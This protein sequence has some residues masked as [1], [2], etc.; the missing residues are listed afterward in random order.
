[1][2][3]IVSALED[4]AAISAS[5]STVE[6]EYEHILQ[7]L[8]EGDN[9]VVTSLRQNKVKTLRDLFDFLKDQGKVNALK[10][11]NR[12]GAFVHVSQDRKV[13]LGFIISFIN[14]LQNSYGT[15]SLSPYPIV[16]T[17]RP[18]QFEMFVSEKD[19]YDSYDNEDDNVYGDD[20][21]YADGEWNVHAA[22]AGFGRRRDQLPKDV[23]DSLDPA[24]RKIWLSMPTDAREKTCPTNPTPNTVGTQPTN[25]PRSAL[26]TPISCG[27]RAN[28]TDTVAHDD[29]SPTATSTEVNMT[30]AEANDTIP[31]NLSLTQAI[32][33][34]PI[35]A[36]QSSLLPS[37]IHRM[38]SSQDK[39][40]VIRQRIGVLLAVC[41]LV[42]L[43][44]GFALKPVILL[45]YVQ[46]MG[47]WRLEIL[48]IPSFSSRMV[49]VRSMMIPRLLVASSASPPLMD[50]SSH[51]ISRMDYPTCKCPTRLMK[52]W[53][54]C[55]M[56]Y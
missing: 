25:P 31:A 51:W 23:Y 36:H 46:N 32:A 1:M 54:I 28:L 24:V 8:L 41:V 12:K 17:T 18:S 43:L 34:A 27:S 44:Q 6:R 26:R 33:R 48:S 13:E 29:T 47:R 52:I 11:K 7:V 15:I 16:S 30:G 22:A 40:P 9:I 50:T 35:A 3:S 56:K 14:D 42:H 49:A 19:L 38:M 37:D 45:S 5:S 2:A 55:R 53:R 21:Y 4:S 10:A 39:S 20:G